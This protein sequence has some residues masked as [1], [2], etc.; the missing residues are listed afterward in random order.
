MKQS[1][2]HTPHNTGSR[3]FGHGVFIDGVLVINNDALGYMMTTSIQ[4]MDERLGKIFGS[5]RKIDVLLY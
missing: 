3:Y 1:A 5:L 2:R 4:I